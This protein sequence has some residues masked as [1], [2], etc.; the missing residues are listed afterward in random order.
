MLSRA[1]KLNTDDLGLHNPIRS[2]FREFRLTVDFS[3]LSASSF[4][5][6]AGGLVTVQKRN[7]FAWLRG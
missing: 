5:T 4:E 6:H 7:K 2:P 1:T 3:S